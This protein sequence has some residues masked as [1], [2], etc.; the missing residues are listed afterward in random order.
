MCRILSVFAV[1]LITGMVVLYFLAKSIYDGR[2]NERCTTSL[3]DS[4]ELSEFETL[5]AKRYTFRSKQGHQ[6]V[7]YLYKQND[8]AMQSKGV[9][10]FAH[11]L[12]AGGQNGYMDIFH[13]LTEQGFHVFAYDA[14]AND[15]SEGEK[16]GGLPQGII[17]LDYAIDCVHGIEEVRDLPFGLMGYSWG[18]LSVTNVLNYHPEVKAVVSLA[19]CNRSTD[20]IEYHGIKMVGKSAKWLV[21]FV[22]L[23]EYLKYGK[24]A[25]STALKGF[26]NSNCR[27][28][29]VHG[30]NDRTVPIE[31]GYDVFYEKY[32]TD[33]RFVFKKYEHRDH[34][35][36]DLY[37]GTRDYELLGEIA[38]FFDQSMN[39]ER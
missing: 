37:K 18:A 7:G 38:A 39:V 33:E 26:A 1:L 6:L 17:D 29:I 9:I 21:P 24:Y 34:D 36:A 15:E 4:F 5:A 13:Y 14:T 10:V 28:M 31:Y 30:A 35:I 25:F 8:S 2:F 27:V 32:A 16:I 11:G 20:L 22:R 23:H 3:K 19:G 12:G